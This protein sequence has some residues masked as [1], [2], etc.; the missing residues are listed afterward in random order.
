MVLNPEIHQ[1]LNSH[2]NSSGPEKPRALHYFY[3]R[4]A[5]YTELIKSNVSGFVLPVIDR[6]L[7]CSTEPNYFLPKC[8]Y[9]V[10]P[11]LFGKNGLK[12]SVNVSEFCR[13]IVFAEHVLFNQSVSGG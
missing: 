1:K 7:F 9:I 6:T 12:C 4:M 10:L 13:S 5:T 3:N 8:I 2:L 11:P